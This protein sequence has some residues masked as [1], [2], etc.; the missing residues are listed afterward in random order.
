MTSF[1]T[2]MYKSHVK[3]QSDEGPARLSLTSYTEQFKYDAEHSHFLTY[4]KWYTELNGHMLKENRLKLN[5]DKCHQA[6][7]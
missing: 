2:H 1:I 5:Q 6:Q 3:L 4:K 7:F